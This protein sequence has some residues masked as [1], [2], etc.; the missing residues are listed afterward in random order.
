[1]AMHDAKSKGGRAAAEVL[2]KAMEPLDGISSSKVVG[3]ETVGW[4][5]RAFYCI[6]GIWKG[7]AN[8]S[9]VLLEPFFIDSKLGVHDRYRTSEGLAEL[10]AAIG[11]G[12]VE[13]LGPV[14]K[15]AKKK[16]AKKP[17]A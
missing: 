16:P 5:R 3:C 2:A 13:Y 12:A 7:P 11:A 8:I 1:M 10:G 6:K 15:P 9:G 14:K 17:A 4:T